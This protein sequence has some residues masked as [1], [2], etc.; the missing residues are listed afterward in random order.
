MIGHS[1]F[2]EGS[3]QISLRDISNWK[4]LKQ[5]FNPYFDGEIHKT[6]IR[7]IAENNSTN[8]LKMAK[9]TQLASRRRPPVSVCQKLFGDN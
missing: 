3:Y 4:R 9:M 2:P 6:T 5:K 8:M 1:S 7:W